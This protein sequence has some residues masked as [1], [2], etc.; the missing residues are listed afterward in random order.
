MANKQQMTSAKCSELNIS[1][2]IQDNASRY[3]PKYAIDFLYTWTLLSEINMIHN[4]VAM[5]II[6]N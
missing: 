1:Y 5:P 6:T 4:I 2:I 3:Y